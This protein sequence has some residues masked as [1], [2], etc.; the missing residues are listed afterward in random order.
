[1]TVD[2]DTVADLLA[3]E[4]RRAVVRALADGQRRELDELAEEVVA[5]L[6]GDD[7]AY[8]TQA[9]K[10]MYVSLY[11]THIP[12]LVAADVIRADERTRNIRPGRN[13][14]IVQKALSELDH[15]VGPAEPEPSGIR[16]VLRSIGVGRP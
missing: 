5:A 1:M 6:D 7:D 3:N 14:G 15:V 11:Q 9:G 13:F 10:R 4:R 12:D 2:I 16:S 8:T